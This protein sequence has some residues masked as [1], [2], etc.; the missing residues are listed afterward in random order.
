[1]LVVGDHIVRI[2][3]Q[4]IPFHPIQCLPVIVLRKSK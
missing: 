4:D 1:M 2:D 3:S